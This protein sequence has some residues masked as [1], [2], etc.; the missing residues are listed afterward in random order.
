MPAAVGALW[1]KRELTFR[2]VWRTVPHTMEGV[3]LT[4]KTG[5]WMSADL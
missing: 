3:R 2:E 5:D 1:Q 4:A